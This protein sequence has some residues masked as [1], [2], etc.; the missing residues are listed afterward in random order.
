MES[1][2]RGT[3]VYAARL[4]GM[5]LRPITVRYGKVLRKKSYDEMFVANRICSSGFLTRANHVFFLLV[6]RENVWYT[7]PYCGTRT[8]LNHIRQPGPLAAR[9]TSIRRLTLEIVSYGCLL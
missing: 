9:R 7:Y 1:K 3:V 8:T 2:A 5:G 4:Y 6:P